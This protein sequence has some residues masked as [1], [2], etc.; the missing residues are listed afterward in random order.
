MTAVGLAEVVADEDDADRRERRQFEDSSV[1]LLSYRY[2]LPNRDDECRDRGELPPLRGLYDD[3]DE[4]EIFERP[5]TNRKGKK[6]ASED[7]AT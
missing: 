1:L 4:E 3:E 6:K 2:R 5:R 7:A